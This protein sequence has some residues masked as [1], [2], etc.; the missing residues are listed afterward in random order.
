MLFNTVFV[1]HVSM[2]G[3]HQMNED[4]N[5]SQFVSLEVRS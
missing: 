2:Q 1:S 5:D 4:F 3:D